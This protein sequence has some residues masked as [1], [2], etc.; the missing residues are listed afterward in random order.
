MGV[1]HCFSIIRMAPGQSAP[2]YTRPDPAALLALALARPRAAL[3]AAGALLAEQPGPYQAS[4]ARHAIGIVLRDRGDMAEAVRQLQQA[5]ALARSSGDAER[6][7]DVQATLGV[8]LAWMGRTR[9]GL[10]LLDQAVGAS[11]GV[12]AGRVLMR[13]AQVR[14]ELGRF[15]EAQDDLSRALPVFRRAGDTV[16]EARSLNWRAEVLLA[17]GQPRRA[18]ADYRRAEELFAVTGQ[19]LEYA[20]ARHNRGLVAMF[21][22]RLPEALGYLDEA[23]RRYAAL[24]ERNPDLD[25]DRCFALLGAGLATEAASETDAALARIAPGGG[26]A[27][28]RAELLYAAATAAL[29]AGS[30]GHA[31]EHAAKAHRLFLAQHRDGWATRADLAF[32]QARFG[33]GERTVSLYR[34]IELIASRLETRPG[35]DA[36]RAHLLAGRLAM[37][38]RTAAGAKARPAA[39]HARLDAGVQAH[40]EAAA[41]ARRR[42]LPLARSEGW[43]AVALLAGQRDAGGAT[44]RACA[45][46]LDALDEHQKMFGAAELRAHATAHGAELAALAQRQ[47]AAVGDARGLLRWS[48]RWRATS[49]SYRNPRISD[50]AE[51]GASLTALRS[52]TRA[53]AGVG[54]T[55]PGHGALERE[56]R[57][58]EVAV[59]ARTRQLPDSREQYAGRFNFDAL[60]A[61][62]GD[63]SLIELVDVE[64]VLH[65]VTVTR[66]RARLHVIGDM[67]GGEV[68][69]CRFTLRRLAGHRSPRP[70]DEKVLAVRA[71]RLEDALLGQAIAGI[72]DG[73]VVIVPPGRLHAVPWNMMPSLTN[74]PVSVAPSAW[75]WVQASRRKP[76]AR[77]RVSL[78]WGPALATGPGEVSTLAVR[79]PGAQVLGQGDATVA[80]VLAAMDGAWLAH[81]AAHGQFR[82]D[83]PMFS[84]LRLDDGPLLVHDLEQLRRAPHLLVLPSCDS[85]AAAAVGSDEVL[86]LASSLIS[87]GAAGIVAS[88]VPV[89]DEATVPLMLALHETLGGATTLAEALM[90]ARTSQINGDPVASAAAHSFLALGA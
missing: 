73:P 68:E 36:T 30:P 46:G 11:R 37:S 33:A 58:L 28:K 84:S 6:E 22:G 14:K 61:E 4:F 15:A 70:G 57:R 85:A 63:S 86:G 53:L 43:L 44:L 90:T 81:I 1:D 62:L 5:V 66:G 16:W 64:G 27:Y 89:N 24:G 71:R 35:E 77:R 32:A 20:K 13:R 7:M 82:A 51:L 25:F 79:Y 65:V 69:M 80:R 31:K 50:D 87:L 26:I 59:Q 34:R 17:L 67:P 39:A 75:S 10:A 38:L 54:R 12:A 72:P 8:T 60:A 76:P 45:R 3:L 52:V 42:R 41:R 19:D 29:A 74:R 48:E 78:V 55:A 83:S 40:L 56:R 47:M 88:V 18:A 2:G 21:T 49:L 23:S 9:S